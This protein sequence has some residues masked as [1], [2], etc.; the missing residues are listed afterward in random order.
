[1]VRHAQVWRQYFV[2]SIAD[3]RLLN[4]CP[5]RSDFLDR[6]IRELQMATSQPLG[7]TVQYSITALAALGLA[8]YYAWDLA[9]ITLGTIPLAA[10]VLAKISARMQPVVKLHLEELTRASKMAN[11]SIA[12]IDTVKC[13]NGQDFE[14][15]Q[16]ANAVKRAAEHY[17]GQ[18]RCNA[19]QIGFVRFATL[20]MFV[21]GFWYGTHLV[22]TGKKNPGDILTAFWA[23]LMATQTIE[24]IL[25]Q[26]IVL[27]KGRA[28]G[29]TLR[30]VL[31][32]MKRG[33]KVI[34][35]LGSKTPKYCDGDIQA[36]DVSHAVIV[37]SVF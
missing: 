17:L 21:Q 2:E 12:S 13:Y 29:A 3:V 22:N 30:A 24:Q 23:C 28:A 19:L 4:C 15:W 8:L 10:V 34:K 1:M 26:M 18:A 36:K 31:T 25:P 27:E 32:Q 37:A 11:V 7:F 16:Y 9:L 6:H 5:T 35:M 20:S 33:C 14:I